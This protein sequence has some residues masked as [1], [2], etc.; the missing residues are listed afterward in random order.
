MRV[1]GN[2]VECEADE[3]SLRC[4][5]EKLEDG[6]EMVTWIRLIAVARRKSFK[7]FLGELPDRR[8]PVSG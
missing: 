8:V 1:G 7:I 6:T 3:V 2:R 4:L 5:H